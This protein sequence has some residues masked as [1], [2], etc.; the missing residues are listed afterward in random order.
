MYSG[1]IKTETIHPSHLLSWIIKVFVNFVLVVLHSSTASSVTQ[2]MTE[3]SLSCEEKGA[4]G[5]K[6][7]L[8]EPG[9]YQIWTCISPQRIYTE[10]SSQIQAYYS[11][12]Q[13]KTAVLPE[14]SVLSETSSLQQAGMIVYIPW[15]DQHLVSTEAYFSLISLIWIN[16]WG[17]SCT[18]VSSTALWQHCQRIYLFIYL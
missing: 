3:M 2:Q 16:H 9:G 1:T 17:H 14:T 8:T 4:S 10:T 15:E 5:S 13:A 7:E 18:A 6:V 11:V 12:M